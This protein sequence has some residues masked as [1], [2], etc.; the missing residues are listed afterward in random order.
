MFVKNVSY[1][2]K[3]KI[4]ECETPILK[5]K[6]SNKPRFAII[7]FLALGF[8]ERRDCEAIRSTRMS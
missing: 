6:L 7:N 2:L 4:K 8:S 1:F 3:L 5:T